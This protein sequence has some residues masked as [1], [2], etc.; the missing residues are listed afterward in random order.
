[1]G[2][3]TG[4]LLQKIVRDSVA[5]FIRLLSSRISS[6]DLVVFSRTK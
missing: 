6:S 2:L 3:E 5:S 1:M 4:D